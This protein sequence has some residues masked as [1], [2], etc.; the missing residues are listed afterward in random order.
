MRR[1]AAA[2]AAALCL[3]ATLA[4]PA[5]TAA[6]GESDDGGWRPVDYPPVNYPAGERCDFPFRTEPILDE[7]MVKTVATYPDG[8]PK[9][10]LYKG[11]LIV[12]VTNLETG[13]SYDADAGGRSIV[14][15]APDGG[16][17]YYATGPVLIGFK[18]NQGN[19]PRGEYLVDGVYTLEITAAD[20]R[21]VTWKEGT[22]K[23]TDVCNKV[24]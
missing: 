22:K 12:R 5:A 2:T 15:Y 13:A 16:H 20:Y 1:Y 7:T 14:R 4:A 9:T 19:L 6:G 3:T 18:E 8:S 10:E 11:A 21:T 17:I 23:L 24:A